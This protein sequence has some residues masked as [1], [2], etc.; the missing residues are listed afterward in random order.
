MSTA[1][2]TRVVDDLKLKK[3]KTK[4]LYITPEQAAT[5]TFQ[6]LATALYK[7]GLLSYFVVDEAH[8]VSQWGH[9]FRPDYL[10]LGALR[11]RYPNMPCVALTATATPHVVEDIIKCLDLRQPLA[12]FKSG[13]FRSN[14]FYE[15]KCKEMIE[16]PYQDLKDFALKSLDVS[17]KEMKEG[18]PN[19]VS[20]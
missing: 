1:D 4:L 18:E 19:W 15:V 2:R 8:C 9:D 5:Q 6:V 3:P 17:A 12:R 13:S 14:L 20:I 7:R 16:D 11:K 10:K